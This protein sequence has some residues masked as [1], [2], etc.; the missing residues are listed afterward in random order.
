[1]CYLASGSEYITFSTLAAGH[2]MEVHT[3]PFPARQG[4]INR[5]FFSIAEILGDRSVGVILTGRGTDGAEG[6][7]EIHRVGGRTLVQD[8]R[9]CLW[10][11]MPRTAIEKGRV[12]R[13]GPQSEL[14]R[15][16]EDSIASKAETV[17][18]DPCP[19]LSG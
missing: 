9:F 17:E 2:A 5:L 11:E 7:G 13:I 8:P 14:I 15:E 6:L 19:I 18:K 1:V 4:S 10:S 3:A 16:L 12:D